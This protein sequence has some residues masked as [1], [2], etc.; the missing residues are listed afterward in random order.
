MSRVSG[1][2]SIAFLAQSQVVEQS[3]LIVMELLSVEGEPS[4]LE[5]S[6]RDIWECGVK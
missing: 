4:V 3:R 1:L 5:T 2:A 6:H